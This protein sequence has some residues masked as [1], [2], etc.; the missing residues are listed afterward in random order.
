MPSFTL[1]SAISASIYKA[2]GVSVDGS[3]VYKDFVSS[4]RKISGAFNHT[5]PA[6]QVFVTGRSTPAETW[7]YLVSYRSCLDD[8]LSTFLDAHLLSV[9]VTP[10]ST[11]SPFAQNFPIGK[12]IVI[13]IQGAEL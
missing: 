12:E 13:K 6:K 2:T 8:D 3:A 11:S 7:R 1:S 4:V 10:R 5:G 9:F